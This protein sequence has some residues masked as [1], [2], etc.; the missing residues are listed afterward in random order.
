MV[1]E[2]TL[3]W[4]KPLCYIFYQE[5]GLGGVPF[6]PG[7]NTAIFDNLKQQVDEMKPEEKSLFDE[8]SLKEGLMDNPGEDSIF[9]IRRFQFHWRF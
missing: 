4:R 3:T 2:I 1:K 8:I 6:Q 7:F 9:R 5:K